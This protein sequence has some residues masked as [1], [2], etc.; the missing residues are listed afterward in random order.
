MQFLENSS[1]G[2]NCV[3]DYTAATHVC[4]NQN[5]NDKAKYKVCLTDAT[6]DLEACSLEDLI[7]DDNKFKKYDVDSTAY[8]N[9]KQVLETQRE[10]EALLKAVTLTYHRY[11]EKKAG[12]LKAEAFKKYE[13][14]FQAEKNS[15]DLEV[16][17]T[18]KRNQ[19]DEAGTSE[20]QHNE[21]VEKYMK[22]LTKFKDLLA[23]NAKDFKIAD[24]VRQEAQL[25]YNEAKKAKAEAKEAY[26]QKVRDIYHNGKLT[27]AYTR[28]L[29]TE[30]GNIREAEAK[31]LELIYSRE[32]QPKH[33][34]RDGVKVS[35]WLAGPEM[36]PEKHDFFRAKPH[37]V[38]TEKEQIVKDTQSSL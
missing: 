36:E 24:G 15:I 14:K 29:N 21:M 7:L 13:N 16:K 35:A 18:K 32:V 4:M 20:S 38:F 17:I 6:M 27:D 19:I 25:E 34:E 10:M 30:V 31:L 8:M 28:V 5:E 22:S 26:E 1:H 9:L 23:K 3:S 33:I 11:E 12:S 37:A 2:V